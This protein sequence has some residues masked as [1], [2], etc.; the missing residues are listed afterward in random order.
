MSSRLDGQ[1][2]LSVGAGDA[3][4][5]YGVAAALYP[6]LAQTRHTFLDVLRDV[7]VGV[8]AAGVVDGYVLVGML[9]AFAVLDCDGGILADAAHSHA[10]VRGQRPGN[11][12]FCAFG[13]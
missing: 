8:H 1:A 6:R 3:V 12:Y 11:V 5:S 13:I 2:T 7:R 4:Q 9:D 10:D